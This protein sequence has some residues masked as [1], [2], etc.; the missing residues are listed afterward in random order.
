MSI[1]NAEVSFS[2]VFCHVIDIFFLVRSLVRRSL[3]IRWYVVSNYAFL[4]FVRD[5][6]LIANIRPFAKNKARLILLTDGGEAV[7]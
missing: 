2:D 3:A 7:G 5:Q 6:W 1:V 4:L